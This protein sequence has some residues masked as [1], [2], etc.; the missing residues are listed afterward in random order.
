MTDSAPSDGEGPARIDASSLPEEVL[1]RTTA[2]YLCSPANPHGVGLQALSWVST[3]P[4][5]ASSELSPGGL[6]V[7][8][9]WPLRFRF[10]GAFSH[11]QQKDMA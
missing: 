5:I 1:R 9:T 7:S 4:Y 6:Q 11:Q 8:S 2:A 3:K 10:F